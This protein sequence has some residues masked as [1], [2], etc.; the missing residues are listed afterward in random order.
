[1][2]LEQT[3][4]TPAVVGIVPRK[5]IWDIVKNEQ[6]YHIPQKSAPKNVHRY[7]YIAF[8][9]PSIFKKELR[10][11]VIYYA[12]VLDIELVKRGDLFPNE[13]QHKRVQQHY[14]KFK[15]DK[16]LELPKPIPSKRWRFIVHIPTS[17]ER[18]FSAEEINDLYDTSPLEDVMYSGLKMRKIRPERQ[19]Y[20]YI[21]NSIYCLDF[22]IFCNK[23]DIDV[24]CDGETFHNMPESLTKDRK[25]NNKLTSHGWSVLR[26]GTRDI[27]NEIDTCLETVTRTIDYLGGTK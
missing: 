3:S 6:W 11:K 5:Q 2:I 13:P 27:R 20:V 7:Q 14:Y 26:F 21:D 23:G 4:K 15:L 10:Y 1:M 16:L 25:R 12:K 24:E 19:I 22:G 8:Y 17:L 9:L 18:L